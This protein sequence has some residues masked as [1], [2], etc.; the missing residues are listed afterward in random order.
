MKQTTSDISRALRQLVA[1]LLVLIGCYNVAAADIAYSD[2]INTAILVEGSYPIFWTNDQEHPWIVEENTVTS[3]LW[4]SENSEYFESST[5]MFTYDSEYRIKLNF[6]Y[7]RP[8]HIW[9]D[10]IK[11]EGLYVFLDDQLLGIFVSEDWKSIGYIFPA[12]AHTIKLV[13]E[14]GEANG[15]LS[16]DYYSRPKVQLRKV[17]AWECKEIGTGSS[18]SSL[19]M[20]LTFDNDPDYPWFAEDGYIQAHASKETSFS[21]TFT[22][23]RHVIF[24]C[25]YYAWEGI[26]TLNVDNKPL[27]PINSGTPSETMVLAP[28]THTIEFKI[29]PNENNRATGYVENLMIYDKWIDVNLAEPGDLGREIMYQVQNLNE[30]SLLSIKGSLNAADWSTIK[31][32]SLWAIDLRETDITSLPDE[33]FRDCPKLTTVLFPESLV[34]IGNYAFDIDDYYYDDDWGTAY[35]QSR[36]TFKL[37]A[38]LKSIGRAAWAY[39]NGLVSITF[40]ENSQLESIGIEAFKGCRKLT[41]FIMPN[42]VTS[43]PYDYGSY[44]GTI[45]YTAHQFSDCTSLS[46]LK[47]SDNINYI[48]PYFAYNC[49]QL[50]KIEL[51][52]SLTRI[53][54]YAFYDNSIE[55]INFPN[56]L[57]YIDD[58]AFR[59]NK[60]YTLTL[61]K[62]LTA[63]GSYAFANCETTKVTLNTHTQEM[64]YTF[65]NCNNLEIVVCPAPTPPTILYNANR[66]GYEYPFYGCG[67]SNIKLVV[68]DFAAVDYKIDDY[69]RLFNV[70]EG[71]EAS[72]ADTWYLYG[73]L[74]VTDNARIRNTPNFIVNWGSNLNIYGDTDQKFNHFRYA[75]S[76]SSSGTTVYYSKCDKV[77]AN[78]MDIYYSLY[79]PNTWYFFSPAADINVA[80]ITNFHTDSWVIR[81]YN[82]SKRA[83]NNG[84]SNWDNVTSG[85]LKKGKGYVA[86]SNVS[87]TLKLPIPVENHSQF[88]GKDE[89]EIE[90]N[91]YPSSNIANSNWNLIGNPYPCYFDI[92]YMD[93]EAPITVWT[94]SSYRALSLKD[95]NYA[96]RP[97]QAFFVQKPEVGAEAV[98]LSDGR[99]KTSTIL[100]GSGSGKAPART[101]STSKRDL[102]D[103][104]ISLDGDTV[105]A[106]M[107][108]IVLNE[109]ASLGY[110]TKCDASKFMSLDTSV[111]QIYSMD[112]D[113][114]ALAINERPYADG[115]VRLCV[116]IP[117]KAS[118]YRIEAP[119]ADG[120]VYLYDAKLGIEHDLTMAAYI[121]T[122]DMEGV[123]STRF[124]LRFEPGT[125]N[126]DSSDSD[127]IRVNAARG[128][129]YVTAPDGASVNIYS[130]NGTNEAYATST[131]TT[132]NFILEKGIYV[133]N[134]DGEIFK[135]VVK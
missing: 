33:A 4:D 75:Y 49:T 55:E 7:K 65:A 135:T 81:E 48:P 9:N 93:L 5:L 116:Y 39:N 92:Y 14:L 67:I 20:P 32:M 91:E 57:N 109:E 120:K 69:W 63:I 103:I 77:T 104:E 98:M 45:Y 86:Q 2:D 127:N 117:S 6:E 94:G 119:R 24:G 133:V 35:V 8:E 16:Y 118:T 25:T 123:N 61:P 34:S 27:S 125:T 108:R 68:P 73:S 126:I 131:G 37:P 76:N 124:T 83:L 54:K 47:F 17:R 107:T 58:Y 64:S 50:N 96:L 115:N 79:Q 43:L 1:L 36:K 62:N 105:A 121:F 85:I 101:P 112:K 130:V 38:S 82:G 74:T 42:S 134:V 19:S 31:N 97:M 70:E 28:G 113:G 80:E 100:H 29:S 95:D 22:V 66:Y 56:T 41:E 72:I 59:G 99:Q 53:G 13:N 102:F 51:P 21:T 46:Y 106:D 3:N 30:V 89:V 10:N 11:E 110:E 84:Q 26:F 12:G 90:L 132:L 40:E 87:S 88:L 52:S 44:S 111:A 114:I 23:N 128:A 71:D 78:S 122:S 15:N 18:I 129:I 60:L